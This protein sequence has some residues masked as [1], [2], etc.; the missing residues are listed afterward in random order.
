MKTL[1]NRPDVQAVL[2]ILS[3]RA[4]QPYP[5]KTGMR[6][7]DSVGETWIGAV[8]WNVGTLIQDYPQTFLLAGFTIVFGTLVTIWQI[9]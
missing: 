6:M 9:I 1:R 2:R 3:A 4:K 8:V 5:Q 7:D